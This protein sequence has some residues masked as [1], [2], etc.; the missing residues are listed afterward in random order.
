MNHGEILT[1]AIDKAID[2]GWDASRS[3]W[4]WKRPH[5]AGRHGYAPTDA[6][7]KY[8]AQLIFDPAF[9]QA[10]W[11]DELAYLV[12]YRSPYQP[13]TAESKIVDWQY[14]LQQMVIVPSWL[15]YLEEHR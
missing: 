5:G 12:E 14:H 7:V 9:A 11:G 8:P 13:E 6:C 4:V 10:L 3:R 2:G 15:K 1:D